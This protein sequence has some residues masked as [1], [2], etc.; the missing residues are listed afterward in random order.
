MLPL[1]TDATEAHT[2][3]RIHH[4]LAGMEPAGNKGRN[5]GRRP[6]LVQALA[7]QGYQVEACSMSSISDG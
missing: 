7:D 2:R 3:D 1:K 6:E 5:T 4:A